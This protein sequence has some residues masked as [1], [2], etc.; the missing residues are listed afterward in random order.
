MFVVQLY[1]HCIRILVRSTIPEERVVIDTLVS[2][3]EETE[4]S[5]VVSHPS[6]QTP[7][8]SAIVQPSDQPTLSTLLPPVQGS[9]LT[10]ASSVDSLLS[11]HKSTLLHQDTSIQPIQFSGCGWEDENDVKTKPHNNAVST[12]EKKKIQLDQMRASMRV[13]IS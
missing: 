11:T 8:E 9:T 13:R 5:I 7:S 1:G 10:K 12:I 6:P 3:I 4:D 2:F